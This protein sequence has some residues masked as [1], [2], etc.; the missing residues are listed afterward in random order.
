MKIPLLFFAA[1]AAF[2]LGAADFD[3]GNYIRS[4]CRAGEREIVLP[5]GEL[6]CRGTVELGREFRNLTIRM[7][8]FTDEFLVRVKLEQLEREREKNAAGME[9]R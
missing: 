6:R 3:L 1:A 9:S 5:D 7:D 8:N 2:S 4:R